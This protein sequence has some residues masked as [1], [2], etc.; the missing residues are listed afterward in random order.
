MRILVLL[1]LVLA[2]IPIACKPEAAQADAAAETQ[3]PVAPA[4]DSLS[5]MPAASGEGHDFTFLTH[6]LWHYNGVVG[7]EELGPEPFK[8]EW[9]DFDPNGTF[10]AGKGK[11]ETHHGTWAYNEEEK[12]LGI[13]P[14]D[15]AFKSSE[16]KVMFNNQTMVWVGTKAFGNQSTQIRLVRHENRPE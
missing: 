16:W 10:V 15:A 3:A 13:R 7:P 5:G 1:F 14:L 11:D 6:Q 12:L 2:L 9:I 8:N 4:P